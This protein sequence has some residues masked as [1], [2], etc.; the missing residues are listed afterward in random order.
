MFAESVLNSLAK[1]AGLPRALENWKPAPDSTVSSEGY[2]FVKNRRFAAKDGKARAHQ[3]SL[4]RR[5]ADSA[6]APGV[7]PMADQAAAHLRDGGGRVNAMQ[8]REDARSAVPGYGMLN[9]PLRHDVKLLNRKIDAE[10]L[11]AVRRGETTVPFPSRDI[12][13]THGYQEYARQSLANRDEASRRNRIAELN[14]RLQK[15]RSASSPAA[16]ADNPANSWGHP[17]VDAKAREIVDKLK[18][19][20]FPAAPTADQIQERLERNPEL[21]RLSDELRDHFKGRDAADRKV[22]NVTLGVG[23]GALAALA[24]YGLYRH[25]KKRKDEKSE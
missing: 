4:M 19:H 1:L 7:R 6:K 25:F 13:A 17:D 21:Q 10:S 2:K 24:G 14:Q 16:S 22:R 5:I 11:R 15:I 12:I 3:I 20:S 9:A 8:A 23:A 18:S